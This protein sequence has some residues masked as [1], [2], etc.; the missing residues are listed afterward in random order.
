MLLKSDYDEQFRCSNLGEHGLLFTF[1]ND[2]DPYQAQRESDNAW[3]T[4]LGNKFKSLQELEQ[5]LTITKFEV[6]SL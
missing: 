1:P 2:Y 3:T 6:F 4:G 5:D